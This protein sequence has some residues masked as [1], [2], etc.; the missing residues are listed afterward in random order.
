[1]YTCVKRRLLWLLPT[2]HLPRHI[3]HLTSLFSLPPLPVLPFLAFRC[4][5]RGGEGKEMDVGG[6]GG[7]R[8]ASINPPATRRTKLGETEV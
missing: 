3:G 2:A 5:E 8:G 4:D 6:E 7:E 1:M